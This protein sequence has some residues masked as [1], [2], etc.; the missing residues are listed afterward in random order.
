M[1]SRLFCGKCLIRPLRWICLLLACGLILAGCSGT[2][3]AAFGPAV[4]AE[5]LESADKDAVLAYFKLAED[6]FLI[7][8]YILADSD[9]DLLDQNTADDNE[10]VTLDS[11]TRYLGILGG[12]QNSIAQI[13]ADAP[14]RAVPEQEDLM[15][16]RDSHQA[17]FEMAGSLLA[18][19]EQILNY[20]YALI[21]MGTNLET[22]GYYDENDLEGTYQ[23]ISAALTA[24]I[25]LLKGQ[26]VPT[27]LKNMNDNLIDALVEMDEAVLYSLQAAYLSD[28][29]RLDSAAYRM[30]I[31]TRRFDKIIASVDQDMSD[32]ETKL[33]EEIGLIQQTNSGLKN[34]VAQ[35]VDKLKAN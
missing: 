33:A 16:F 21:T 7:V 32:R 5:T 25:D 23:T 19:Y 1:F 11:I 28:P 31:L 26:D 20:S 8:D 12:Y 4:A 24:T 2:M 35:N 17:M 15:K 22:L 3:S 6:D 13:M 30:D 9:L 14:L 34:W 29:L 27:F 10:E 18:E